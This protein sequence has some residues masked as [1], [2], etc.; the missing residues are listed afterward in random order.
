MA[1]I[2]FQQLEYQLNQIYQQLR[3]NPTGQA[4]AES[5]PV[6][7][8]ISQGIAF[9]TTNVDLSSESAVMSQQFTDL[10]ATPNF[11]TLSID[12]STD[13]SIQCRLCKMAVAIAFAAVTILVT[14]TTSA[15]FIAAMDAGTLNA[16]L[17]KFAVIVGSTIKTVDTLLKA[18]LDSEATLTG[19]IN[20]FITK[21]C[22]L[23]GICIPSPLATA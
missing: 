19:I 9:P 11:N 12:L 4:Y 10:F 3:A 8:L 18:V 5:E 17:W 21:I 6:Q 13:T 1:S 23:L 7:Y 14:G 15:V 2:E 20:A 16:A 22:E